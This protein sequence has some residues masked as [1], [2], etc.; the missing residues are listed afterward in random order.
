MLKKAIKTEH[1]A[2][3]E[4]CNFVFCNKV[5]FAKTE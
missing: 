3:V 4:F 1:D 5:P 2:T